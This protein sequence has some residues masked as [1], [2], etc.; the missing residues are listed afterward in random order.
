MTNWHISLAEAYEDTDDQGDARVMK[1]PSVSSEVRAKDI[2]T[3]RI[4]GEETRVAI[5]E[6]GGRGRSYTTLD[7]RLCL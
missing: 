5:L 7:R 4:W 3:S 1:S 2:G 6:I